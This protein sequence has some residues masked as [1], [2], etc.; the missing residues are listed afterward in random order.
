MGCE[1]IT[2]GALLGGEIMNKQQSENE[3]I[4]Q[5]T[6]ERFKSIELNDEQLDAIVVGTKKTASPILHEAA[7]RGTHL[8]AVTIEF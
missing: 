3:I 8:P 1:A 2:P 6:G 4:R 7:T 5:A